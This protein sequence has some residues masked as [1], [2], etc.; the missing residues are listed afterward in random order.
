MGTKLGQRHAQKPWVK[1]SG[2]SQVVQD[3]GKTSRQWTGEIWLEPGPLQTTTIPG[4]TLKWGLSPTTKHL[5][6]PE[7]NA[8]RVRTERIQF[9]TEVKQ[10]RERTFCSLLSD[11]CPKKR[12]A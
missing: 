1:P 9:I 5:Q 3:V 10:E 11:D 2:Q 8:Q 7:K 6:L 4:K 12:T